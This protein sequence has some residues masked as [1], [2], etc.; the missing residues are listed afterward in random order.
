MAAALWEPFSLRMV[1][2]LRTTEQGKVAFLNTLRN[3]PC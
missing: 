3:V 2:E 1:G